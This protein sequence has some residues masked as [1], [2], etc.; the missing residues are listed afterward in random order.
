MYQIFPHTADIGLSVEGKSLNELFE[1][2]ALGMTSLLTEPSK[3][4][5][6]QSVPLSLRSESW[7]FLLLDW[8]MEILYQFTVKKIAF[9]RFEIRTLEPYR[10]EALG[11]GE[12]ILPDR[13]PVLHEI[14]S[15]TYHDLKIQKT[16]G[17]YST[18][19][20]FDI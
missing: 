11:W 7:E 2:S 18:R 3:L 10:I 16:G 14:K 1:S 5:P 6:S 4:A 15:V 19:I 13:H 8:L 17:G 12:T 9:S 20:I